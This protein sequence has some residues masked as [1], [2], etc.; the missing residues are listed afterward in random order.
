MRNME[1]KGYQ[2]VAKDPIILQPVIGGYLIVTA[3]GDEAGDN[4]VVNEVKN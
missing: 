4:L 3:W 2:I 1:K